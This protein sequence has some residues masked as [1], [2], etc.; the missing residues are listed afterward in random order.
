MFRIIITVLFLIAIAILIVMNIGSAA[1][2]NVFGWKIEQLPVT[3][4]AIVSF[5]GGVVYSFIFYVLSY[6][7]RGRRERLEKKKKKLRDQA[8]SLKTREQEVDDLADE[9]KQQ[10]ETA[11]KLQA[12]PPQ[13]VMRSALSNLFGRGKSREEAVVPAAKEPA[14]KPKSRS[15][16]K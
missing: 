10:L 5:V 2:V 12:P 13:P 15:K 6:L 7:E 8:A 1:D 16:K 3:V 11:R 14:E 9:S 4:A